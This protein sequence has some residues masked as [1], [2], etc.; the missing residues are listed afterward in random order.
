MQEKEEVMNKFFSTVNLLALL[1][2][3]LVFKGIQTQEPLYVV[4]AAIYEVAV[5][6]AKIAE[7]S[8]EERKTDNA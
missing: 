6:I 8:S 4:A 1:S 7:K 3:V 5:Q 2:L